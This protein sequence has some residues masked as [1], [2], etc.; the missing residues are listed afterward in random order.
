MK[1]LILKW[2]F[3]K[4]VKEIKYNYLREIRGMVL[5]TDRKYDEK[6]RG[7]GIIVDNLIDKYEQEEIKSN[8][9]A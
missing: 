8:S 3:E 5:F 1:K 6:L 4:D 9:I 7:I 2:F